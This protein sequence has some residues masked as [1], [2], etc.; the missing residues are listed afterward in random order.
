M[1]KDAVRQFDKGTAKHGS[2]REY[3]RALYRHRFLYEEYNAYKLWD[4]DKK[5]W[6]EY[7]SDREMQCIYRKVVQ[8]NVANCFSDKLDGLEV[9]A[10]FVHR[11]WMNPDAMGF[12]VF[13]DLVM[14]TDCIAKPRRGMKGQGVFFIRKGGDENRIKELYQYCRKNHFIVEE[15]HCLSMPSRN[16]KS[17]P[18][19]SVRPRK[20]IYL[21]LSGRACTVLYIDLNL[22]LTIRNSPPHDL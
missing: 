7:I 16:N 2:L 8:I 4:L 1:W 21:Y 14:S 19:I 11:R 5:R 17:M 9:F 6:G 10:K 13:K 12:E 20:S 22:E 3:K 18:M 15:R